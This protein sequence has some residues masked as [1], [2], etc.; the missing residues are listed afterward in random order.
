M[1]GAR[2][3]LVLFL[4][5]FLDA[6]AAWLALHPPSLSAIGGR[7][8]QPISSGR[9]AQAILWESAAFILKLPI[10]FLLGLTFFGLIHLAYLDL[11]VTLPALG[12]FLLLA[13]FLPQK[14]I[15]SGPLSRGARALA[16]LSLIGIPLGVYATFIE[17]FR[18]QVE[19]A[20]VPIPG[21]RAGTNPLRIGVLA[22]IQTARVTEYERDAVERAMAWRPDVILLPGD[23]YQGW[24]E[25]FEE[26]LPRF[27][28]LLSRL[29]APGGVYSVL[30][31]VDDRGMVERILEGTAVRLL[32]NEIVKVR[33]GDRSLTIGG[34]EL[35]HDSP[36][37]LGTIRELEGNP[38]RGDIRILL[39]HMPDPVLSLEPRTRID[40]VV[41]GHTHGGQVQV[42]PIGPLLTLSR[43]PRRVAAGGLHDLDG[44]RIYVS[45]GVGCERWQAPRIRFFCPPEVSLLTLSPKEADR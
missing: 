24:K 23:L 12:A 20:S 21:E 13:P 18:L 15:L 41:A 32:A 28:D 9:L 26:E 27:R 31:N 45:R 17:P 44:R 1:S 42:P 37:A 7:T 34:L 3:T 29:R 6:A 22:D 14:R 25:D 4:S 30:G 2:F 39:S 10:L 5:I 33:V 19:S 35:R 38:E 8:P 11:V 16:L 43:V 40:L 36:G